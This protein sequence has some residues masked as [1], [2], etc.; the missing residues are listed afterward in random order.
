M[1]KDLNYNMLC[2]FEQPHNIYLVTLSGST[3]EVFC[4]LGVSKYNVKTRFQNENNYVVIESS[5][6]LLKDGITARGIESLIKER[7]ILTNN[8]QYQPNKKINGYT[9]CFKFD[10]YNQINATIDNII[11]KNNLTCEFNYYNNLPTK[12][13]VC[14]YFTYQLEEQYQISKFEKIKDELILK[15]VKDDE[16]IFN[17]LVIFD[18]I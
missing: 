8:I 14:D 15:K 13:D 11:N 6:Y 1:N 16:L 17:D 2:G 10:Y 4:K 5:T 7:L 12:I 18:N 9:E 3:G